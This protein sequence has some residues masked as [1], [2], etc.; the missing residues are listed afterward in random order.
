MGSFLL[1]C[2]LGMICINYGFL[3][4]LADTVHGASRSPVSGKSELVVGKLKWFKWS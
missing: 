3:E 2:I 4:A 1:F